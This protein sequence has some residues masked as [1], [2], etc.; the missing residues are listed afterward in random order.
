MYLSYHE[1]SE[2]EVKVPCKAPDNDTYCIK[3]TKEAHTEFDI[4]SQNN[5]QEGHCK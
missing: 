3:P 2:N 5:G 4:S 1:P